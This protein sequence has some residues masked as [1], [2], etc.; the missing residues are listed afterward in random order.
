MSGQE[1]WKNAVLAREARIKL[2]GVKKS[3]PFHLSPDL[4]RKHQQ[5]ARGNK[6]RKKGADSRETKGAGGDRKIEGLIHS[7]QGTK[8]VET[9]LT[10]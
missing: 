6:E 4:G 3:S 10:Y 2:E 5:L 7:A 8:N 9:G 1:R